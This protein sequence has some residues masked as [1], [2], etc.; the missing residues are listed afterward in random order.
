MYVKDI[1]VQ[2]LMVTVRNS[3]TD[4][5]GLLILFS[6]TPSSLLASSLGRCQ[7]NRPHMNQFEA[8]ARSNGYSY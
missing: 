8:I 5:S 2:L 1:V 6:S 3:K 7:L 4:N